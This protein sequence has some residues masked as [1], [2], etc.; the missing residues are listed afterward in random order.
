M[1]K[2]NEELTPI[3]ADLQ[4]EHERLEK[5][6]KDLEQMSRSRDKAESEKDQIQK[7]IER[8]EK[9]LLAE[10]E[11]VLFSIQYFFLSIHLD[12]RYPRSETSRLGCKMR[13][14]CEEAQLRVCSF[15]QGQSLRGQ[16]T[17]LSRLD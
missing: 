17:G 15:P 11:K 10:Q 16:P 6:E 7:D 3:L 4:G 9:E 13:S 5:E 12:R 8:L 14:C 2:K 1:L